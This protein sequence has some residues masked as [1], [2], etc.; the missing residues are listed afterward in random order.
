MKVRLVSRKVLIAIVL[1][2]AT[3]KNRL[4]LSSSVSLYLSVYLCLPVWCYLSICVR[5]STA[6]GRL[7]EVPMDGRLCG[8]YL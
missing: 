4:P 7:S 3:R 1:T 8:V 5:V 6:C 2:P